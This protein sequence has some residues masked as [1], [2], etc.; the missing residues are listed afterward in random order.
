MDVITFN[1]DNQDVTQTR[2]NF[3]MRN[4]SQYVLIDQNQNIIKSWFGHLDETTMTAELDQ[5]LSGLGF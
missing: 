5:L 4:R 1:V 2:Y 3:G